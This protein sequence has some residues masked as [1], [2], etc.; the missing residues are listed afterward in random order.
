MRLSLVRRRTWIA[1]GS[2]LTL[3]AVAVLA[4]TR[5]EQRP[6]LTPPQETLLSQSAEPLA[7]PQQTQPS[8]SAALLETAPPAEDPNVLVYIASTP[9]GA[10][11]VRRSDNSVLGYTPET[12]QFRRSTEP[13]QVRLELAGF[14][15]EMRLVPTVSD[16]QLIVVLKTRSRGSRP[17]NAT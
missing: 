4:L 7:P 2:T 11:I 15:P 16:S 8:P 14:A 9:P 17:R 10:A 3:V 13:V 12:I 5:L 1:L 6:A